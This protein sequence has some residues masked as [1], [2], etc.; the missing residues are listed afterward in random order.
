MQQEGER[1]E[2]N[3]RNAERKNER[4]GNQTESVLKKTKIG[5]EGMPKETKEKT[6]A[7]ERVSE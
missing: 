1:G 2:E 4:E 6:R 7:S 3:V 5:K